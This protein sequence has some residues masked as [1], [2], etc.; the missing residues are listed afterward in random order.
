MKVTVTYFA[1]LR[2]QSGVGQE[3]I[4]FHGT[5]P[6]SLYHQVQKEHN[7]SL[8]QRLVRAAVN[9]RFVANDHPLCDGDEVVFIPPVAGG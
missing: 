7:L 2:Q 4:E 1:V 8:D 9:G 6:E 5:T 3:V